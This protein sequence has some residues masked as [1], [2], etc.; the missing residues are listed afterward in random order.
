MIP[1]NQKFDADE[2]IDVLLKKKKLRFFQSQKVH[3]KI[4]EYGKSTLKI[5]KVYKNE[6]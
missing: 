2:F 3:G 4:M 1:K 6:I 5:Y